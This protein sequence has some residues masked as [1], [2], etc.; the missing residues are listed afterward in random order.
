MG[1]YTVAKPLWEKPLVR[2]RRVWDDNV[3]IVFDQILPCMFT[4]SVMKL[5]LEFIV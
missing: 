3:N 5:M 1:N 2:Y 4:V